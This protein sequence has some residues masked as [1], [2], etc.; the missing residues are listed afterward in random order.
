MLDG[1]RRVRRSEMRLIM[2][3]HQRRVHLGMHNL[4]RRQRDWRPSRNIRWNR[5]GR[6]RLGRIC[7]DY[8]RHRRREMGLCRNRCID[9]LAI[10]GRASWCDHRYVC[11]I[12]DIVHVVVIDRDMH[13]FMDDRRCAGHYRWRGANGRRH[14]QSKVGARWRWNKYAFGP[15]R[16]RPGGNADG[17]NTDRNIDAQ[18]RSHKSHARSGPEAI[19]E[20]NGAAAMFVIRINPA[21]PRTGRSDPTAMRSYPVTLP[22]PI[23]SGPN[24]SFVR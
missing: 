17:H 24:S 23:A 1:D 13:T 4:W 2:L 3:M 5:F 11:D 9:R 15:Y 7:L 8:W 12:G 6:C 10:G 21:I 20:H 16:S 22:N 18:R 19:D 14:N